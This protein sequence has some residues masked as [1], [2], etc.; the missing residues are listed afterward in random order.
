MTT[1]A[2]IFK[3]EVSR[4]ARKE[5]KAEVDALRKQTVSLRAEIGLLKKELKS[6]QRAVSDAATL[7]RS[8]ATAPAGGGD[9]E[10][11]ATRLK[12]GPKVVFS[13]QRL[14]DERQRLGLTQEQAAGLLGV[15]S[16]SVWK[17]ETGNAT[18]RASKLPGILKMMSMGKREAQAA[19]ANLA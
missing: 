7:A 3:K 5:I 10:D 8:R 19:A 17:W 4:L 18:P 9:V 12:P 11:R 6:L 2:D 13:S 14:K 15:S 16:L 1:F